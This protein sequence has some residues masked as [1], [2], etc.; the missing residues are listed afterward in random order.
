MHRNNDIYQYRERIAKVKS[1]Y[2]SYNQGIGLGLG[3]E[4][5]HLQ[6]EQ[7]KHAVQVVKP[8]NEN[9]ERFSHKMLQ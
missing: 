7:F 1:H 8:L 3:H 5:S 4:M 2:A 6:V 9:T